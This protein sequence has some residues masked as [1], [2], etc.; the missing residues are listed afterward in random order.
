MSSAAPVIVWFRQDLRLADNPALSFA[1]G[2]GAP[3][4]ALYVLDDAG[5]GAWAPG[6]ASR[7]WLQGSLLSLAAD[8]R[9][10]GIALVLRRGAAQAALDAVIAETG[11][12]S[13]LWNR[14]YEPALRQRD[15]A[16]KSALSARGIAARSFNAGLLFEPWTIATQ[17]G[18]PYKVYTPF[19]R[20][21]RAAEAPPLPVA[22]PERLRAP[23][24]A[25]ASDD[26]E[27]WQLAPR[28]PDW[29]GGLRESWQPGEVGAQKRLARFLAEAVDGYKEERNR[30][31]IEA[32]SRLSPHLHFGEIS[33]RQLWH[34][35][36]AR[37]GAGPQHFI[38]ELLW[39]EFAHHL[40]FHFPTLPERN[41][42]AEFDAFPWRDGTEGLR[43]LAARAHRLSDRRCRDARA[44]A[45]GLDAQ[46]RAHDRRLL[47]GEASADRL[48]AR[49]GVV[50]GHA[51]RCRPREQCREL[52]MGGGLRRRCRALFPRLQSR[53]AGRE[54][55]SGSGD[56][57][58]RYVPELAR[59]PAKWIHRPW[60][61]DAATLRAAG[62]VLDGNYPQTIVDH[63]EARVRALAA[64]AKLKQIA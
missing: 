21:C 39:R 27:S 56:Y 32:T 45:H 3:V 20:A 51:G 60:E 38:S 64:F 58:R 8:L 63:G 28:R 5:H 33:P 62:V 46:P 9:S 26:L 14:C 11:A 36:M 29:A 1:A 49:R 53:P 30:P 57:V 37:E 23:D 52:A 47:P 55:R 48:A 40:L 13:V 10:R 61:A 18:Q 2:S 15:E 41:W 4:V 17:S 34:A 16:I 6:G 54:V 42:K 31:D 35:A 7:W 43:G 50:L 19:A 22:A 24:V 25:I 12:G 44:L 59:M